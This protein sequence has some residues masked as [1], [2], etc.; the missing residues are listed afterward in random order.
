MTITAQTKRRAGMMTFREQRRDF[1][2]RRSKSVL[3]VLS[4]DYQSKERQCW[5]AWKR[6]FQRWS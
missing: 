4:Q 1:L 2:P 3:I 5:R 6:K